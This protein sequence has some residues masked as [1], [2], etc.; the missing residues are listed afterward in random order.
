VGL[1]ASLVMPH[2]VNRTCA[3]AMLDPWRARA[4]EGLHGT[5]V[6]VGFGPGLN[7]AHYPATVRRVHAVEPASRAWRLAAPR[8]ARSPVPIELAGLDGHELALEDDSCDSALVT[9]T[10]CTL[11][12]A[13]RAL[14]ELHRVLR[15]GG[16]LHLLEHG[17]APDRSTARWQRFLDPLE[18]RVAD[19]CRLTREPLRLVAAAGFETSWSEQRYA[20]GPKPWSYFTVAAARKRP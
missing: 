5:V 15:P 11:R 4:C 12:D 10:L 9:F 13:P 18:R 16:T 19:G 7:V 3:A 17:L 2:V 20:R 8:V 6:E 1:Y 14:G